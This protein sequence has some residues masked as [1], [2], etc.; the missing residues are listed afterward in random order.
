MKRIVLLSLLVIIGVTV[1]TQDT[2]TA[3]VAKN[4]IG[5]EITVC[6]KVV[7][8]K[9]LAS[10]NGKPTYLNLDKKYPNHIFTIVIWEEV[11]KEFDFKPEVYYLNKEVCVYGRVSVY[12]EKP[13]IE[14]KSSSQLS[15]K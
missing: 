13:Q 7:S 11:R 2:I 10:S 3:N 1:Y 14:I 12:K 8:P 5:K 9:F 6:G 4:Y 15:E